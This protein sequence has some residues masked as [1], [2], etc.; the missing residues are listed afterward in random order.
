M[1]IT[2]RR[3]QIDATGEAR[4]VFSRDGHARQEIFDVR[5]PELTALVAAITAKIPSPL[6]ATATDEERT[7]ARASARAS[8]DARHAAMLARSR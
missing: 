5:G 7:A 3:I 1:S 4:V 2:I 8:R 6:P